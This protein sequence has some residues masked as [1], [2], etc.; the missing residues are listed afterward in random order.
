MPVPFHPALITFAPNLRA[1][2]A[3]LKSIV[4]SLKEA[5]VFSGLPWL[6]LNGRDGTW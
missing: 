5:E 3:S 1:W 2:S 4:I 6:Q